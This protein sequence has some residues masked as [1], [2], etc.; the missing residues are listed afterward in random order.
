MKKAI[1]NVCAVGGALLG[2]YT[3]LYAGLALGVGY[4][5]TSNKDEWPIVETSAEA[6]E[7]FAKT[8][9]VTRWLVN[10]GGLTG[11]Y[12]AEKNLTN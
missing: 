1:K 2:A 9:N 10:L 8:G 12:N 5:L 6:A 7:D 11:K 3:I 4:G